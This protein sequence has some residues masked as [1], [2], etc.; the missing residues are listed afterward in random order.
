MKNQIGIEIS[1][2]AVRIASVARRRGRARLVAWAEVGLPPGA[3]ADG[4]VVEQAVVRSAV[5]EAA[6][7][8][9]VARR[10]LGSPPRVRI[11]VSGLRAITRQIELPAMPDDDLEAA[12]RLQALEVVPFPT[13]RTLLSTRRLG[14]SGSTERVNV[15]LEAAHRDLVEPIVATVTAAGFLVEGIELSSSALVR[16]LAGGSSEGPEAIVSVGAELTTLVVHEAGEVRFVRTIAAGGAMV[17]RSLASTLDMAFDDAEAM[18]IRLGSASGVASTVPAEAVAAARDASALLLSEIRSSVVYYASMPGS[19]EVGRVVL[20][21]GGALLA[22]LAERLQFQMAAPVV[23]RSCLETLG[24]VRVAADPALV[25]SRGAVAVGLALAEPGPKG[26]AGLLPP[27]VI[28]LRRR[29]RLER[30]VL[31]G[32]GV[33]VLAAGAGGAARYLQVRR[34]QQGLSSLTTSIGVLERDLPAYDK[35]QALEQAALADEQLAQPLVSHEV[36]WPAVLQALVNFTPPQVSTI[37]LTGAAG[38]SPGTPVAG[39]G[40]TA[41]TTAA[42]AATTPAGAGLSSPSAPASLPGAG[43]VLGTVNLSLSSAD[44]PGFQAW[45]D[46]MDSSRDFQVVQYSGLTSSSTTVDFTAQLDLTGLLHS[47]RLQRFEGFRP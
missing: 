33:V 3:V 11:A 5:V 4:G 26:A 7:A 22:G 28:S 1:S 25:G 39:A 30:M 42:A 17:T 19:A 10:P 41:T 12:A 36:A 8:A 15:L 27:E 35:A 32:I 40:G 13:E 6:R 21:G 47:T 43:L 24:K 38:T 31:A 20:V 23:H 37:S 16:A 46:S 9:K 34:A 45:F 18:K 29:Q 14:G 44:Y 2:T